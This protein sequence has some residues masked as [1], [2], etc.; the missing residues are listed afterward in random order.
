MPPDDPYSDPDLYELEF[1]DY[2]EDR[3]WYRDLATRSGGPVVELGCGTG[4]LTLPLARA[5]VAVVGVD[6]S[7]AMLTHLRTR[8][9]QLPNEAAG[10]VTL[11]RADFRTWEASRRYPLVILPFNA[12]HHCENLA[13][14]VRTFSAA[15]GALTPDG[16]FAYDA[17]LPTPALRSATGAPG[18]ERWLRAPDTGQTLFSWEHSRWDPDGPTWHVRYR[19]RA[20]DGTTR[21]LELPLR[22]FRRDQLLT[23][24]KRAGLR[25]TSEASDFAAGPCTPDAIKYVTTLDRASYSAP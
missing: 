19:Y 10:R 4:R 6:R 20:P 7:A 24:A 8:L 9:E 23:A 3:T 13:E 1:A 25:P 18:A 22:L 17:Y 2:H 15:R 5:G 12:I 11:E 16:T 14:V 21:R